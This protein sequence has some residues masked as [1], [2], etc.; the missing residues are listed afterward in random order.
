[1]HIGRGASRK[2]NYHLNNGAPPLL[3][4]EKSCD[5]RVQVLE[6]LLPQG[7]GKIEA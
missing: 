2:N 5:V 4:I 1:M 3:N 6:Y 7:R